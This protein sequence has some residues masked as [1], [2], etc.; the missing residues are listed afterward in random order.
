MLVLRVGYFYQQVFANIGYFWL[1]FLW[2]LTIKHFEIRQDCCSGRGSR[3]T[4]EDPRPN[5][6]QLN[7]EELTANK[8]AAIQQL[9]YENKHF[10][11]VLQGTHCTTGDKRMIPKFSLAGSVL[12]RNHILATFV[13]ERLEWSLVDRYPEQSKTVWLCVD[14]AGYKLINVNKPPCLR[15]T[16]TSIPTFPHP[17]LYVGAFNCQHVKWG[18]NKTSPDGARLHS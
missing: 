10:I 6:L 17:I 11:N 5:I 7:T 4:A 1:T 15:F 3:N 14:I 12:S 8:I 2:S 16:P 18:Y 13:H 9:T